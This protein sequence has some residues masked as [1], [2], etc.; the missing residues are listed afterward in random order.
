MFL[1]LFYFFLTAQ[2]SVLT[3]H[4]PE[5]NIVFVMF[6]N[7]LPQLL[8]ALYRDSTEVARKAITFFLFSL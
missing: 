6:D 3:N 4:E 1:R 2:G 8:F 5:K 7:I